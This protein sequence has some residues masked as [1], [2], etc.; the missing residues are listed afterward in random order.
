MNVLSV[1]SALLSLYRFLVNESFD[2]SFRLHVRVTWK[3]EG[4]DYEGDQDYIRTSCFRECGV[5]LG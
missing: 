1:Q 3:A 5:Q 4:F 2:K